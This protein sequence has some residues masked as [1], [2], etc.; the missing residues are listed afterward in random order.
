MARRGSKST[1]RRSERRKGTATPRKISEG[2][3]VRAVHASSGRS[4]TTVHVEV[5][6]ERVKRQVDRFDKVDEVVAEF[7]SAEDGEHVRWE[8]Q[9]LDK[10]SEHVRPG[11]ERTLRYSG[12]RYD[13]CDAPR[14]GIGVR[15]E[16]PEGT[17]ET[18]RG[19]TLR[20]SDKP[21]DD[22]SAPRED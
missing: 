21:G 22:E 12:T 20:E 7:P 13:G 18:P 4:A 16:T 8:D 1:K 15:L 2:V 17:I 11:G 10:T 6:A 3:T 9:R 14:Y 19:G 5:D